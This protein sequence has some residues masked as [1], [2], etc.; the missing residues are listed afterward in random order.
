VD[1]ASNTL[2]VTAEGQKLLDIVVDMVKELDK[3]AAPTDGTRVVTVPA[4]LSS[5]NLRESLSRMFGTES[6]VVKPQ[7]GQEDGQPKPNEQQPNGNNGR[8]RGRPR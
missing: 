5:A 6:V 3:A 8:G 1:D 2:V 7:E 4:G